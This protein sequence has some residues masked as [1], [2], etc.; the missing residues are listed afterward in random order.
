MIP[1]WSNKVQTDGTH[2]TTISPASRED[3][4]RD[5]LM[6][7]RQGYERI[8]AMGRNISAMVFPGSRGN[9]RLGHFGV[10]SRRAGGQ[11]PGNRRDKY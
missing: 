3:E 2:F 6:E 11:D 10:H 5:F 9:L 7:V 4:V 1:E 8:L